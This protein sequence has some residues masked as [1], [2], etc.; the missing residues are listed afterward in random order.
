MFENVNKVTWN[1]SE[2]GHGK[3]APDKIGDTLKRMCDFAVAHNRDVSNFS[4][5]RECVFLRT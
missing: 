2:A 3:G 4:Q 1:Y 5:F